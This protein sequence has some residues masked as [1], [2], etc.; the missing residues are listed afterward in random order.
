MA[1]WPERL[2]ER[3]CLSRRS[4]AT[5][6]EWLGSAESGASRP[7][8]T[9]VAL[10]KFGAV[11]AAHVVSNSDPTKFS[12]GVGLELMAGQVLKDS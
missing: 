1:G 4:G 5:G 3:R 12:F 8:L 7:A 2:E 10:V 11:I 6:T 9:H